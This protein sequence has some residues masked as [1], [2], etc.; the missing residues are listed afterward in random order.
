MTDRDPWRSLTRYSVVTLIVIFLVVILYLLVN[1]SPST[2]GPRSERDT[3]AA[4]K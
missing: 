2:P 1:R 4:P 3:S